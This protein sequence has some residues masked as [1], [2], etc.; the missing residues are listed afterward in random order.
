MPFNQTISP[1][2]FSIG[3]IEIKFYGLVYV[4]SLLFF[5]WWIKRDKKEF[6]KKIKDFDE[7]ELL[8]YLF[9]GMLIGARLGH[10]FIYNAS[11]YIKHP[12]LIIE[13]W[14]GGMSFFGGLI[15]V[16]ISGIIYS[17]KK[18]ANLLWITD[19][20]VIP[21]PLFLSIGRI[22]NFLN[23]E[24]YGKITSVP[25]CVYF[26]GV[27]GCRHPLQIYNAIK[28]LFIFIVLI[29]LS[30]KKSVK[31]SNGLLFSFFLMLYGALRFISS[32]Y[33]DEPIVLFGLILNHYLSLIMFIAGL[34]LYIHINKKSKMKNGINRTKRK[35][36]E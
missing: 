33:R 23:S 22:A 2:L 12:L 7:Y 36:K 32:F 34:I 4:F 14:K 35:N 18:K 27:I 1:V 16:I 31:K 9:I 10:C 29:Y 28:N 20:L 13:Y 3:S 25:W 8:L 5:L 21:V 17:R 24:L 11:F 15:G 6:E 30:R 19:K 26:Q